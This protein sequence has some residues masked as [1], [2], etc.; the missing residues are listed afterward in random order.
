MYRFVIAALISLFALPASGATCPPLPPGSSSEVDHCSMVYRLVC[1]GPSGRRTLTAFHATVGG[2][3]GLVTALHG[4]VGCEQLRARNLS[5]Q[6]TS[7]SLTAV[8]LPRDAAL[9]TGAG[10]AGDGL[11]VAPGWVD[12]DVRVVGYSS[13]ITGQYDHAL[14]L[15]AITLRPLHQILEPSAHPAIESRRSPSLDTDFFSL[16]GPLSPGYSGAPILTPDGRVIGV[17][18]GGNAGGIAWVGFAAPLSDVS[19]VLLSEAN[20]AV[21]EQLTHLTNLANTGLF[22]DEST[23]IETHKPLPTLLLTDARDR[24]GRILKL[25]NGNLETFYTWGKG[26]IYNLV[27]H[28]KAGLLFSN[29]NDRN[30]NI[31]SMGTTATLFTHDDYLDD[32]AVDPIRNDIF[33][34]ESTG[35]REN[36]MIYRLRDKTATPYREVRLSEVDGFWAGDFAFDPDGFLW[37]S[38]GNRAPANLYRLDRSGAVRIFSSPRPI[39]GF[40]F[41]DKDTIVYTDWKQ[42][43]YRLSLRDLSVEEVGS[44]GVIEWMGDVTVFPNKPSARTPNLNLRLKER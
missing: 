24:E 15:D 7:L 30:L 35:A 3:T 14:T 34:S 40:T 16:A 27:W 11:T 10:L 28:P 1:E 8:D 31:L 4:A 39:K 32:V 17:A 25:E 12:P 43:L 26:T 19:W 41:V 29:A 9:L 6:P 38:S 2:K 37:V 33:F 42:R 22:S 44:F 36:G 20:A 23:A 18:N 13:S 5:G 21:K